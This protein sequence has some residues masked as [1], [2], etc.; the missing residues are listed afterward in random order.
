VGS[1]DP[2]ALVS[3]PEET[4][5]QDGIGRPGHPE[6]EG[7]LGRR[8]TQTLVYVVDILAKR[9]RQPILSPLEGHLTELKSC[10]WMGSQ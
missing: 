5:A 3:L 6:Q 1:A 10:T 2:E 4:V 8:V 7:T 9:L